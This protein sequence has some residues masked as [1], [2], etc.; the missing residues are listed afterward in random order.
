MEKIL[1]YNE[2]INTTLGSFI[3]PNGDFLYNSPG[4]THTAIASEFCNGPN[5]RFLCDAKYSSINSWEFFKYKNNFTGKREDIDLYM[6]SKLTKEQL[7]LYKLYLQ[8]FKYPDPADF[9]LYFL[10]YDKVETTLKTCISTTSDEP[11]IRLYNYYLMD[12]DI[13]WLNPMKIND[14]KNGY[15]FYQTEQSREDMKFEDEIEEIKSKVLV[16]DRPLFFK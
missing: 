12:W 1:P 16:K 6:T 9:L 10:N 5:Y 7:E 11:H 14:N 2:K 8:I 4:K 13:R 3:A 15:V